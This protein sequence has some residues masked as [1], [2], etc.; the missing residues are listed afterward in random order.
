MQWAQHWDDVLFLHYAVAPEALEPQLPPG[1][2]IDT[3][4][5][6]AWLSLIFFRLK[7]RP[8]GWPFL[9][10]FSSLLELNVRTYVRCGGDPGILFLRMYADNWLAIQA[11]KLLTPLRYT[12]AKMSANGRGEREREF[13]CDD[14]RTPGRLDVRFQIADK[15]QPAHQ[16]S[17]DAWLVERYRLYAPSPSGELLAADVEHE[18][19]LVSPVHVTSSEDSIADEL[20]LPLGDANLAH[21]S[22][23][24]TASFK[25]FYRV[26]PT[27]RFMPA[28]KHRPARAAARYDGR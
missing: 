7:L 11:A 21:Y 15:P 14:S 10:G 22:A 1:L 3:F 25:P 9:P 2:E 13:V 18:P 23:G 27:V 5:G 6:Q 28:A 24:V 19:W 16:C 8:A 4:G 20:Q 26:R 12:L 17:L